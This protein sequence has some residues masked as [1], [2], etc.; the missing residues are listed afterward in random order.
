MAKPDITSYFRDVYNVMILAQ[1]IITGYAISKLGLPMLWQAMVAVGVAVAVDLAI[2][3]LKK[4]LTF[5]KSAIITGFIITNVL[6]ANQLWIV[7]AFAAAAIILKHVIRFNGKHIFNPA[8]LALASLIF[9]LPASHDWAGGLS[10]P[11]VIVLG[12]IT[13]FVLKR[14][15][16]PAVFFLSYFVLTA[17]AGLLAG[18]PL[19]AAAQKFIADGAM[20]FFGW[21]MLTEPVTSPITTRGQILFGALTAM[22]AFAISLG[23][24]QFAFPIA[25]VAAD[26]FVPIIDRYIS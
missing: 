21:F 16:L 25:L 23:L 5:P 13:I 26:L 7:A 20:W 19:L 24:P 12:L 22:F 10:I 17:G 8:N 9:I 4:E 15:H 3:H 2:K 18:L 1:I 11:L 14:L 6:A